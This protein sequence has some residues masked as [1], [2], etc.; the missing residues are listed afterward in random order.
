M[1]FLRQNKTLVVYRKPVNMHRSFNG[2]VSLSVTELNVALTD[3]TYV[4]F[5]N[6]K[7]NQFKILFVNRGHIS[8]FC[9]RVSGALQEDFTKLDNIEV[10]ILRQLID[11]PKSRKPCLKHIYGA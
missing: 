5:M 10:K 4:L 8:M 2:L 9:M 11:N 7:R 6:R 1:D 3:S